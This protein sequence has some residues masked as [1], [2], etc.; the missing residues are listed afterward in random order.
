MNQIANNTGFMSE[1]NK[2][3][4]HRETKQEEN[5]KS[6]YADCN[7]HNLVPFKYSYKT[8]IEVI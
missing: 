6:N 7:I 3:R 5:D 2:C 4:V 1:Y 8:L